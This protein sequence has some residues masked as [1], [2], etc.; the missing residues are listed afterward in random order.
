MIAELMKTYETEQTNGS[1]SVTDES[2]NPTVNSTCCV[3]NNNEYIE[4]NAKGTENF[5]ILLEAI[6]ISHVRDEEKNTIQSSESDNATNVG[7]LDMPCEAMLIAQTNN[8]LIGQGKSF[9]SDPDTLPADRLNY[10]CASANANNQTCNSGVTND[11]V[12]SDC[13]SNSL[14]TTL[15]KNQKRGTLTVSRLTVIIKN[16]RQTIRTLRAQVRHIM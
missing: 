8:A 3:K 9:D 15:I 10:V 6:C 1:I 11:E 2:F 12:F 13:N 7:N 4:L 5:D 16:Q 14:E